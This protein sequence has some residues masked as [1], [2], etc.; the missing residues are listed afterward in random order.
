MRL[1][2]L[3]AAALLSTAALAAQPQRVAMP[4]GQ[5]TTLS[6]PAPVSKVTVADPELVQVSQRGRNVVLVARSTGTTEVTVRTVEGELR[7]SVYVA[8]DK[9]GLPAE[10]RLL[11]HSRAPEARGEGAAAV[12]LRQ[13]VRPQERARAEAL[14]KEADQ[15]RRARN[16]EKA[17]LRLEKCVKLA[18]TYPPCYRLLGSVYA[19]LA[20]RDYSPSDMKKARTAYERYV[21]LAPPDDEYVPKVKRILEDSYAD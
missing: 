13:A 4:V 12:Q 9:Y 6:M 1:S 10:P 20:A 14:F 19:A 3:L 17:A 21:E 16:F 11:K 8:A 2:L 15:E 7:L 18:P 5:T